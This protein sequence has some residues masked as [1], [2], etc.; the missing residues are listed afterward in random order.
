MYSVM[1]DRS[2][3]TRERLVVAMGE[4]LRRQGY[5]ATSVKQLTEA[6]GATMG[7]LYHHFPGGKPEVAA[8]ALRAS[9]AAYAD[10]LAVLFDR[11]PELSEAIP[12][13]FALA[14]EHIAEAGW[15]TMCPVGTVAGEVADS[16]PE[17]AAA[18]AEVFVDW[19]AGG[20]AYFARRGLDDDAARELTLA[21][22]SSLEGAFILARSLRSPDPLLAA[23]SALR[24]H[25][26][27]RLGIVGTM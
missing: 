20:T 8:A 7:S 5:G 9:G 2:M 4:L 25:V 22:L 23:G 17:V 1:I 16:E 19:I 18:A 3:P 26:R 21:V 14:A 15:I 27:L 24:E 6:A 10:L 12:D 11:A 13:A